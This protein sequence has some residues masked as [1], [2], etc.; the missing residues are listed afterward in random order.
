MFS[1]SLRKDHYGY[2]FIAPFFIMFFV[3][4]LYPILYS[5]YLS[6]TSWDGFTNP[7]FIGF[8]NYERLVGDFVFWESLF[9]T[10]FI[11]IVSA[12]PQLI[13]ALILAV[14]LNEKFVKGKSIFRALFFFP[15]I[16]TAASLGLLVGLIFSWQQ[17][18]FN[19]LL[20]SLG[21]V[22]SPVNWPTDGWFMRFLT[23]GIL[24]WQYFGYSMI[25]YI[26]G[27]QGI[28]RDLLEAAE[29][30]GASKV[31]VFLRITLPLLKPIIIFQVITSIIGGMQIFDQP[32]TLTNGTGNPDRM[33]LT[34]VMYLY[35]TAFKRYQYGYGSAIAFGLFVVII[36]FSIISFVIM[37]RKTTNPKNA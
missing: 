10:F 18:S 26:A 2:L 35:N 30:D 7:V 20:M 17:G 34:S 14:I 31:Q 4:G 27:L 21:I 37:N 25:I 8:K 12:I 13:I 15:N 28:N 19:H 11:W 1:R 29:I 23:S 33:T 24:F 9:N 36:I 16:V 22:H 6:L 32:F 3:F 5:F